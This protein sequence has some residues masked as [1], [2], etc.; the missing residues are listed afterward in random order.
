MIIATPKIEYD[1]CDF[2]D[3]VTHA[4]S[5]GKDFWSFGLFLSIVEIG[6]KHYL[7]LV[8]GDGIKEILVGGT[9]YRLGVV[10]E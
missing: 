1:N 7:K 8:S 3:F 2:N 10:I 5:F 4:F 9:V 6:F